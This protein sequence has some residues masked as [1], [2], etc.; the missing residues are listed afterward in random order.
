[1]NKIATTLLDS[2][3]GVI[4]ESADIEA[5]GHRVVHGGS[6]FT[7]TTLINEEVKNNIRELFDLAPL[8][9]PANLTGI[10]IAEKCFS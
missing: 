7:A 4:K 5:V 3:H 1:M 9:N 6:K 8:H 2:N 10:E